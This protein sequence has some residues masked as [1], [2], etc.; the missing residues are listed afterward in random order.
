[1]GNFRKKV[2]DL[3]DSRVPYLSK[4][5]FTDK[6]IKFLFLGLIP[7]KVTPNQ[8]TV[9]RFVTV[10]FIIWLLLKDHFLSASILFMFSALSDAIDGALARTT[11][12]ITRWGIL[13]DPLADKL[14]VGSVAVILISKFL[15]WPFAFVIVALELIILASAYYRYKGR[16]IPAKITGKIKMILQCVGIIFL[17]FFVLFGT[18]IWLTLAK[19]TLSLAV[20]FALLSLIVYKSI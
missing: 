19:I 17:F 1:M 5:T 11:N 7:R 8:I 18:I 2:L 12:R 4:V 15:S 3:A 16:V 14:L 10:P 6:I 13:A 9:F 20:V